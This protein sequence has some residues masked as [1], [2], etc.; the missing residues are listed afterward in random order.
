MTVDAHAHAHDA[1]VLVGTPF[2]HYYYQSTSTIFK[3][4][5]SW[6]IGYEISILDKYIDK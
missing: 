5:I 6:P 2:L 4:S 1:R 3:S